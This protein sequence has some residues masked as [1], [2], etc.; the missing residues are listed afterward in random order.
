MS[1]YPRDE[2]DA[3]ELHERHM[4]P[5]TASHAI[6]ARQRLR[7]GLMSRRVRERGGTRSAGPGGLLAR[8]HGYGFVNDPRQFII[9][10]CR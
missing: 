2:Q 10:A 3:A 1:D 5:L 7:G 4:R 6:G 8:A 9:N